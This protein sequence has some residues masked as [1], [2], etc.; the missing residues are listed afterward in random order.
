VNADPANRHPVL[1]DPITGHGTVIASGRARRPNDFGA[2]PPATCPFCP[3]NESQ[4]PPELFAAGREN[5]DANTAGWRLRVVPNKFPAW[6]HPSD[7]VRHE[8]IVETADHEADLTDLAPDH[9]AEVL[10]V[11]LER[12][13]ALMDLDDI[14]HVAV[15][16]NRGEAA[17]ATL[18]HAHGQFVG[19]TEVPPAVVREVSLAEE[20]FQVTGR[21]PTCALLQ[22]A[23]EFEVGGSDE[24]AVLAARVPRVPFECWIVPRVHRAS[25]WRRTT[26]F[27][28]L[29][30]VLQDAI[31]RVTSVT[32]R[33]DYNLIWRSTPGG[34]EDSAACHARIELLPRRARIAGFELGTGLYLGSV[35]GEDA[36]LRL[37]EWRSE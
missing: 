3:G 22:D 13:T 27:G 24:F 34:L 32:G 2:R 30:R 12:A 9:V 21:C 36:A 26:A 1:L 16:R 33:P 19:L 37:R 23:G 15:F 5:D 11:Y 7:H 29:A 14:R 17:G 6:G 20:S 28:S 4:T 18:R 8:V 35:A 31:R 25:W 10:G